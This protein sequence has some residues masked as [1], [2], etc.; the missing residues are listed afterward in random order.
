MFKDNINRWRTASLFYELNTDGFPSCFTTHSVDREVDGVVYKSF[1]RL[2]LAYNHVPGYEYDFAVECLGG[3]EHWLAIRKSKRLAEFIKKCELELDI[4]ARAAA[5][6]SIVTTAAVGE[7]N[8]QLSAAK[9]LAEKGY[10]EKRGRPTKAEREGYLKQE[11]ALHEAVEDDLQ[12]I[13]K[14]VK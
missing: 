9:W 2:Y 8:T 1:S 14:V 11:E 7:G 12:R 10:I 4:K 3:W 13:L 5:I 6:R